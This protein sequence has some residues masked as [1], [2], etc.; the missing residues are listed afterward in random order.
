[1]LIMLVINMLNRLLVKAIELGVLWRLARRE[2]STMGSLYAD[3]M[4]IFYHP[5][6]PELRVVRGMLELFGH[7]SG[8]HTHFAKCSV[9][10]IA[11]SDEVA[12]AMARV[13]ECQLWLPT[14]SST[15]ASLLLSG[16]FRVRRTRRWLIRLQTGYL[17]GELP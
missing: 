6:E 9:S 8:L 17:L 10:P 16:D 14:Q 11:C 7:V 4:V 2:L 1:M 13:M 5:N 3:D 12:I 15:L